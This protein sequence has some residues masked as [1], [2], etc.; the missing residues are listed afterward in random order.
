MRNSCYKTDIEQVTIRRKAPTDK[1]GIE[2]VSIRGYRRVITASDKT[3]T[4][5]DWRWEDNE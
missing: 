5:N 1:G 4:N 2:E 3:W